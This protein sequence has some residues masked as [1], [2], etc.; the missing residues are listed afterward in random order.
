MAIRSK[1]GWVDDA[2]GSNYDYNGTN[3]SGFN[4]LPGG[5][6]SLPAGSNYCY[7]WTSTED[8]SDNAWFVTFDFMLRMYPG[9]VKIHYEELKIKRNGKKDQGYSIRCIKTQ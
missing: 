3:E 4:A 7:W 9:D 8:N 1:S 6:R 2:P 5:T